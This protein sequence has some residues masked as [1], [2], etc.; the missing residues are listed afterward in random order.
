MLN[1]DT[2]IFC[3]NFDWL[4]VIY[5]QQYHATRL[6]IHSSSSFW[7]LCN[8]PHGEYWITSFEYAAIFVSASANS[9]PTMLMWLGTQQIIILFR[10]NDNLMSHENISVIIVYFN[11]M[12]P[13][14]SIRKKSVTL[15]LT[16]AYY[17][18]FISAFSITYSSAVKILI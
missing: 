5:S 9:F 2:E 4:Y 13:P 14:F 17:Y 18:N 15:F 3:L 6:T 12:N 1:E 10:R 7:W 16:V 8:N 11:G